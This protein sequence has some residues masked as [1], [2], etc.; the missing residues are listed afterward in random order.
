MCAISKQEMSRKYMYHK[1]QKYLFMLFKTQLFNGNYVI[2]K[3]FHYM[4]LQFKYFIKMFR[5]VEVINF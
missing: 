3:D 5:F 1:N 2:Y 4:F